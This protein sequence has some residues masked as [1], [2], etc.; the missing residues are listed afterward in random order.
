MKENI[1]LFFYDKEDRQDITENNGESLNPEIEKMLKEIGEETEPMNILDQ[2]FYSEKEYMENSELYYNKDFT[3]KE[4]MKICEYYNI[5]KNIK[6][7]KCKKQDIISTLIYFESL[8][9]NYQI[10]KKRQMMWIYINELIID[11]KMKKYIYW[12]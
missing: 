2:M 10:V 11:P 8:P 5:E 4:L 3:I 9:E 7:S 1:N 6:S 12:N